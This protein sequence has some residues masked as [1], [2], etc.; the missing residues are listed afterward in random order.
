[1]QGGGVI[2]VVTKVVVVTG[3]EYA[4]GPGMIGPIATGPLVET[5]PGIVAWA[6]P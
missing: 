3:T 1:L 6:V 5:A 4:T 2:G